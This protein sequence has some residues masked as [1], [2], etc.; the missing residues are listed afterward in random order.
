VPDIP[1]PPVAKTSAPTPQ[2]VKAL[3]QWLTVITAFHPLT[4]GKPWTFYE[5]IDAY[6]GPWGQSGYPIAY[7]KKYCQLFYA[8]PVLRRDPA[9]AQW[10]QRTLLLLQDELH[11]YI[12]GRYQ[13]GTL[14]T[15]TADQLRDAAFDSHPKAYTQAGLSMIVLLSPGLTKEISLIPATE[16]KPT[17]PG[18]GR[19]VKQ[20]A[21]TTTI[22]VP[23]II[24]TA[25]AAF[26]GPAHNQSF[27][28]A[29]ARDF[30]AFQ[31][32][33]LASIKLDQIRILVQQG[34]CDHLDT[35]DALRAALESTT[36]AD[37]GADNFAATVI[38]EI[39]SRA[40][41]VN[42]RYQRESSRDRE[43]RDIFQEFDERACTWRP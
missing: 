18:F 24:A 40:A 9:G 39:E 3:D 34:Q 7:G 30:A 14:G 38:D 8:D 5:Q 6:L 13:A 29:S 32:D 2:N 42:L 23:E 19:T 15:I 17:S 36:F 26:S 35:L 20:V 4:A 11:R 10:V 43:L 33:R 16:Y 28:V 1:P 31:N 27:Q 21:I 25:L 41:Y 22:I 12:L 37:E